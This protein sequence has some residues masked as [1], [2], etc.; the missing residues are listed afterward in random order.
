M[1]LVTP[2]VRK[3]L[4]E[5]V[6]DGYMCSLGSD[7]MR[8]MLTDKGMTVLLACAARPAQAGSLTKPSLAFER[9]HSDAHQARQ[10]GKLT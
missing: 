8:C 2:E 10:Q 9:M 7:Y 1:L 6:R 4:D 5:L 3:R